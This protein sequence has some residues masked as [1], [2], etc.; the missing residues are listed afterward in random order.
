MFGPQVTSRFFTHATYFSDDTAYLE[1]QRFGGQERTL[2]YLRDGSSKVDTA[3]YPMDYSLS[4]M[5][6]VVHSGVWCEIT[7]DLARALIHLEG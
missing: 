1:H 3:P 4:W 7:H 2:I 5:L 6:G